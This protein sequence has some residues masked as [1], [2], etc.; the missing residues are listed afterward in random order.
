MAYKQ[1][2]VV[3]HS[4][5]GWKSCIRVLAHGQV[6]VTALFQVADCEHLVSSH[7]GKTVS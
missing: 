2:K 3:P 7:D 5:G 1:Q 4:P 6:L